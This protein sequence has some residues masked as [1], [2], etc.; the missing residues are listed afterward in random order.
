MK[1]YRTSFLKAAALLALL[2]SMTFVNSQ[3]ASADCGFTLSSNDQ[4]WTFSA[5]PGASQT[6]SLTITN[7]SG[8]TLTLNLAIT[9]SDAFSVNHTQITL[10]AGD[11]ASVEIGITF[12]P[13][14]TARGSVEGKLT[15]TKANTDC[16]LS[17]GLIGSVTVNNSTDALVADPHE[18]SFG[19]VAL[20][21]TPPCQY[22]TVTNK[23]NSPVI[24]TGWDRCDNNDFSINASFTALDTL[25]GGQAVHFKVCY[26]PNSAHLQATCSIT[27]HYITTD[28]VSDGHT[29]VISF[30]GSVKTTTNGGDAALVADPHEFNFG[31]VAV[32][33]KV[34]HDII[35]TN[36][37]TATLLNFTQFVKNCD[38]PDITITPGMFDIF[39]PGTSKTVTICFT[40]SR[41]G[42]QLSCSYS[43]KYSNPNTSHDGSLVIYFSGNSGTDSNTTHHTVCLHTE[44]GANYHDAVVVGGTAEHTLYLINTSSFAITINS[45][46][47]TGVNANLFAVTS[48]LPL[49]VPANSTNT[50][51]TYTFSPVSNS[52]EGFKAELNL[53]ISGDSIQCEHATGVLIGFVVHSNANM[54][55]TVRPLFPNEK[56]TLGVEGNGRV[57]S[58]TFYF[59]NNLSVDCTVNKVYLADGTFFTITSTIPTPTP[60]VLH[61]GDNLTVVVTYTATD[62]LVHHDHLMIDANHNLQAQ[63]FDLQ[64]V[65]LTAASVTNVLPAGVA[66][67]VSPNPA[68]NYLTVDMAGIRS[69]DVQ[70]IDLLG[71][72]VAATKSNTTWRWNA[73]NF[74]AGSYIVR[75][76]GESM[77][78]EQF[79]A[80]KRVIVSK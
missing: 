49:T 45:A 61:P 21:T 27:I 63:D 41:A 18:F 39:A 68:S 11:T 73:S 80:S 55:S 25:P 32:G 53:N 10:H 65:Q 58:T 29:T 5:Y 56:R 67:S 42:E 8:V 76:A 40:P 46:T 38:N 48:T 70:V 2:F 1:P 23:T 75:V 3:T 79:V 33:T 71:K 62:N 15:I 6:R 44:Q 22:I 16:N 57:T 60:F 19:A 34:C 54:D 50:T 47:I 37:S 36:K 64:G 30:G 43:L 59:T 28:P 72:T 31:T 74:T 20:D 26:T 69:A 35:V 14:S 17:L 78:G 77:N 12:H 66:I 24:I 52:S 7:T 51:L 9:G 13:G 4:V